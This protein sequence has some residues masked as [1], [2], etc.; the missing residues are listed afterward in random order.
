MN[1]FLDVLIDRQDELIGA[2][3]EHIQISFIALF[4]AVVIAIPLGIYLTRYKRIAEGAIGVTAV[5]QTIPS[6]ALLGLLIPLFGIGRIPAII[7]LVIYALLPILRNTYTGIN[8]VDPSLVEAGRA[9]GMNRRKLLMKI[10]LPLALPVI[11]AG[12]R[13]AMVLIVGTATLAA[14]IGAGGLGDLILLG[15]DR[16]DTSLIVL[17]AIP[18]ALLA[19]LF[20]ILLRQF[21]RISF[22]KAL[23][24]LGAVSAAALLII[25]LPFAMGEEKKDIVIAGKLGAEPEILINMYKLL[26]EEDTDLQ[27]T[28]KPGLGKTSFVFNA[29]KTGNIDLYPEFTGTAIS[30]FLKETATSTDEGAVYEQARKGMLKEFNME[31]LKPMDYNN[32]YTLA[33]PQSLAEKSQLKTISDLQK[34]EQEIKA[35]FTLEFSDREDGYRG[36]QKLYNIQFPNVKTMEPKLRY[37]A[38]KTGDINLVDAYSTD[39]ELRQYQ[40]TVLED[41]KHLFPP[42]QGAPILRKETLDDHPE[43]RKALNK[44]AGKITDDEMRKMNYQVNVERKGA[45]EV[46]REY[47][48]KEGLLN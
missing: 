40:L 12:I 32:T 2:L 46:A 4:F 15:I 27:V 6:L 9:M 25:V 17:G 41:D 37:Q 13:T 8:E 42:Y 36:I 31:M 43:I 47:L 24:I 20:D 29:L 28:L 16:N 5:L 44:L 22:K 1:N 35:G 26:I 33:V 18:A 3:L 48:E 23:V 39:S 10:E 19:I 14:L 21:E 7:A 30:E 45:N 11:M 38:I 34:V